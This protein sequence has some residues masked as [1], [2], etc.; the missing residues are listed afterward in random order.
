MKHR[1]EIINW[2]IQKRGYTRYLEVGVKDG[3]CYDRVKCRQKVGVDIDLKTKASGA[4][5]ISSD[6]FFAADNGL[7]DIIFIDGDHREAQVDLDIKNAVM[8]LVSDGT[9]V[10]HDC[11]PKKA[12][13]AT[14][15]R[16]QD[17]PLW[18][19]TAYRSFIKIRKQGYLSACVVD[20]DWGCGI[21]QVG[22]PDIVSVPNNYTWA[23]FDANRKEWL[24]LITVEEFKRRFK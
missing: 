14:P 19:G 21:V 18:S 1:W 23:D 9:I 24:D 5:E 13:Y 17:Q 4:G 10:M 7:F 2:L 15:E 16:G 6:D 12:I 20:I 11:N 8:H 22:E 3:Y